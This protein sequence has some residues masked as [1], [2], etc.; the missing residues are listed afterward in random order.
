MNNMKFYEMAQYLFGPVPPGDEWIYMFIALFLFC[1]LFMF[2]AF[3]IG[4]F[5]K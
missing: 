2:V 4:R 5:W 3:I 1:G